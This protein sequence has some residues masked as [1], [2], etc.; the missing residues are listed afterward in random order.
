[1][2]CPKLSSYVHKLKNVR[3]P[4]RLLLWGGSAQY[5]KQLVMGPID[6][7]SYTFSVR[8]LLMLLVLKRK[9]PEVFHFDEPYR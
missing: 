2:I 8:F 7:A 6:T 4:K 1:M 3:D 5:S 9:V